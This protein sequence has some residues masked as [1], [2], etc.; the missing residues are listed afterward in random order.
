MIRI[1]KLELYIVFAAFILALFVIG[2]FWAF[3]RGEPVAYTLKQP[4]ATNSTTTANMTK[5]VDSEAVKTDPS[6]VDQSTVTHQGLAKLIEPKTVKALVLG[7]AVAESRGATNKD[8]SAWYAL[9]SKDLRDKYPGN[10]QWIFKTTT[11]AT[12]ND[13]LK[14][15]PEVTQDTD[16]VIIC[17]GRNDWRRVKLTE[18]KQK[19]EQLLVDLKAKSPLIDI[20]LVVEPPVKDVEQNNKFFPYRKIIMDLGQKHDLPVI[21]EWSAYIND[22]T[23]LD[24]LLANGVNPNDKGYRVFADEV[25]KEFNKSL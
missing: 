3:N 17:L 11:S 5:A 10:L 20:F 13:V 23:P 6:V 14:Y 22:P 24:E 2:I 16:L 7:D 21:D 25:L 4:S 15:I 19:Y 12:I 8:E 9:I 1:T 18:F